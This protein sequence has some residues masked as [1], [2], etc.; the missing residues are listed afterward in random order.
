MAAIAFFDLDRT[1]IAINSARAWVRHERKAG[2]IGTRD[3]VRS[4][5]WFAIYRLGYARMDDVVRSAV[6]TLEGQDVDLFTQRTRAFWTREVQPTVRPGAYA[7]LDRH[8]AAGDRLVLL[9]ASS[10]QLGRA[11]AEHFGL[12]DVLANVF[13][14]RNGR[15]TGLAEEPLCYG[16]GKVHHAETYARQHGVSLDDCAF[17]TDSF[18]DWRTLERVGQPVCV[19]PDPR[20]QRLAVER[21]WPIEDWD[22][23]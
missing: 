18:T 16:D 15:F 21:G 22:V 23:R 2:R 11:A 12:D 3:T 9:T 1:L 6:A 10:R 8:R 4:V 19:D 13:E 5:W 20:L 7:A 14:E 17:Y